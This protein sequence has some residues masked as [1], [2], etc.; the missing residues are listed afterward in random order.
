MDFVTIDKLGVRVSRLG[1]G[2]MRFPTTPDGAIDEPRAAKMLD[3]A[4]KAGVNYFDTAYFYHGKKSEEFTGRALK[5]YPR[6]SFF[7]ATKMPMYSIDSL[8][9]AKEVFEEQLRNL[10]VE[11]IDFYLLHCLSKETWKKTLE[12]GIIDY[13]LEQKKLGRIRFF[14]F[15]FHDDYDCFEQIVTYRDWDFCQIQFNYMDTEEQ[16]GMKGYELCVSRNIPVIVME[17]VKGGSLATLADDVAAIFKAARPEKSVASWAMRWVGSLDNC[18]VILSGMS[19]EEQ[20]EDN[21]ATFHG[22]EPLTQQEHAVIAEVAAA[23]RARTFVGCTKCKYC[24]PCPFGVNIPRNF[25]MMNQFMM[26]N[27]QDSM[28]WAWNDMGAEKNAAACKNCG[29]CETLCPQHIAIREKLAEIAAH[30]ANR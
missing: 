21:L 6:D 27:N 23:I 7:V 10:Q 30:M 4:Y 8:D 2:C 26:Y 1:F 13:M 19:N 3:T 5:A 11:C 18:K 22:F 25:T 28:D 9:K 17:P 24:M 20:V 14:G 12:L 29:K 15:S 16:A